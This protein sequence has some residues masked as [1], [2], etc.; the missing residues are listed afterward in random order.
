MRAKDR[1]IKAVKHE[2]PD[3]VPRMYRDVPEVR[4]RLLK[5]FDCRDDDELF[6]KL[7]IDVRWVDPAY[8]G[9]KLDDPVSGRRKS[10]FGVE[11]TYHRNISG[12]YWEPVC[13]P[14]QNEDD[15]KVLKDY[16][17][18]QVDWFDF[19][20]ME[21]QFSAYADYA[22]M[23]APN[24]H[25]SPGI[26]TVIQDLFGMEKA[27][28][29]MYANPEFWKETAKYIMEFNIAF[30]SRLFEQ[31]KGRIDFFRIG[32]DYGTQ[33]GLLFSPEH[34]REFL[35]PHNMEMVKLAKSHGAFFYQH[36]CGGIRD[37]IPD[38]I[39][40][41]VDVLDPVQVLAAGMEPEGLKRDFGKDL[42]FS[43][44]VDEQE[45][46][47]KGTPQEV[48]LAVESLLNVMAPGGGFIIGPTHNFQEDIPTENIEALYA[49]AGRWRYA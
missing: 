10:I 12:G 24:V 26:L 40:I 29:D 11:Y 9:P 4:K 16:P 38:L 22:V 5:D 2:V 3:R 43:G 19:S 8:V 23:T 13:F 42:C 37:L 18:P 46:L 48:G 35:A 25:C 39:Q 31:A 30:L 27:L 14:L 1:V 28:V 44:G 47:P 33:R 41:G 45:L 21:D 20:T 15:P 34:Y 7:E 49:A 17:W 6:E 32:E 36:S